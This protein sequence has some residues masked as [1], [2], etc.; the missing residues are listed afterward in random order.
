MLSRVLAL[1][2]AG[3]TQLVRS[4]VYLNILVA[5]VGLVAAA[6]A[7]DMLAGGVGGR[8]QQDLGLA[9]IS[10]VT[11]VLAGVTGILTVT[12]EIETKQIHL[13][14]AR[15]MQRAEVVLS[16]FLT[17]ATLVV[18]SNLILGSCLAA[19]MWLTG[20]EGALRTLF[21]ALYG[22]WESFILAAVAIF[23]GVGSSSTMS[24]VFTTSL[25]LVSR[26]VPVLGDMIVA[27]KFVGASKT[28][29]LAVYQVL[30]HFFLFDLTD[31]ARG[32]EEVTPFSMLFYAGYG[33][34]YVAALLAAAAWRIERRDLL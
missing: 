11:A 19:V 25:F 2:K 34:A 31:W 4:R 30:P 5:G 9:F 22:S 17:V 1:T 21:A 7:I 10:L 28:V 20:S 14:V 32:S 15:P 12:R 6:V 18:I 24:A 16:R 23:F 26:M 3:L 33:A 29:A 13:V 27:G 8:V